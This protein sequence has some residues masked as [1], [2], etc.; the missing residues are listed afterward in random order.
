MSTWTL[1]ALGAA[2]LVLGGAAPPPPTTYSTATVLRR[3]AVAVLLAL[4]G[5]ASFWISAEALQDPGGWR[6]VGLV[7]AWLI[8]VVALSAL[9]WF[10]PPVAGRVLTVATGVY[11]AGAAWVALAPD[12]TRRFEDRYGPIQLVVLI[13]LLVPL[14]VLGHRRPRWAGAL[15]LT[16]TLVP[17]ALALTVGI[18]GGAALAVV[19]L[20]LLGAAVALLAGG[21]EQTPV[22]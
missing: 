12:A 15:L 4:G 7:A 16:V 1:L 18:G 11:L 13:A 10:R 21:T 19:S 14:A 3:L 6:G 17:L 22:G 20:P 9:A 5:M 2:G 8:P